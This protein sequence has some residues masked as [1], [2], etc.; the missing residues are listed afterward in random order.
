MQWYDEQTPRKSVDNDSTAR[1][2]A[3]KLN[4]TGMN[5]GPFPHLDTLHASR[6]TFLLFMVSTIGVLA[7]LPGQTERWDIREEPARFPGCE[8][9]DDHWERSKCSRDKMLADIYG[10]LCYPLEA[11][12]ACVEGT[13]VVAFIVEIDG[14]ISDPELLRDLGFGTGREALAV[15]KRWI[16]EDLRWIPARQGGEP[17]RSKWCLPIKFTADLEVC[18]FTEEYSVNRVRRLTLPQYCGAGGQEPADTVA[19]TSP[20]PETIDSSRVIGPDDEGVYTLVDRMPHF[21]GCA[22]GTYADAAA[23]RRCADLHLLEYIYCNF[24]YPR[25]ACC[26]QGRAVVAFVVETDGTVSNAELLRDPGHGVGEE[27]LRLVR[28]MNENEIVWEPGLLAGQ[29]VRVRV[30]LPIRFHLE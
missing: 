7:P 9:L 1:Q 16:D 21:P 8:D 2:T 20:L 30:H 28:E 29:P 22:T 24:R 11:R 12:A 19:E 6:L 18:S 4:L 25:T 27:V 3:G 15:V 23:Y 10:K 14:R 5:H 26:Y 17:F 13:A